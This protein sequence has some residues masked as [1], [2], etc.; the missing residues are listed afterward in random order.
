M[1]RRGPPNN[2]YRYRRR[3]LRP[4]NFPRGRWEFWETRRCAA[5]PPPLWLGR[6]SGCGASVH[7]ELTGCPTGPAACAAP[8]REAVPRPGKED[9]AAQAERGG[10]ELSPRSPLFPQ[11]VPS[12]LGGSR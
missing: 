1:V 3:R 4:V 6:G 12:G 10:R 5:A 11:I 9:A 2:R 8:Q 7:S